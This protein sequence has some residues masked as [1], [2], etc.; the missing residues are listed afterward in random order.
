MHA[1]SQQAAKSLHFTIKQRRVYIP[2]LRVLILE[3]YLTICICNKN[4]GEFI[5]F[6]KCCIFS[7]GN[8]AEFPLVVR[9]GLGHAVVPSAAA[10]VHP[11]L[12]S[13]VTRQQAH[14]QRWDFHA[15]HTVTAQ[16]TASPPKEY[17]QK[18]DASLQ[19]YSEQN[20]SECDWRMSTYINELARVSQSPTTST[21]YM[22]CSPY[23]VGR[24]WKEKYFAR[25]LSKT[26]SLWLL[27]CD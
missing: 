26:R 2:R 1:L 25:F 6:H 3:E 17:T 14:W 5:Q 7:R 9:V 12:Q 23:G 22:G 13:Q 4:L 11:L 10:C 27:T 18:S 24:T 8:H 21:V 20:V 16:T 19:A 15:L